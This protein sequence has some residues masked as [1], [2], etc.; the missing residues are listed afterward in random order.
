MFFF[1]HAAHLE[2]W[3]TVTAYEAVTTLL[4]SE[5]IK[6]CESLL[7]VGGGDG[8]YCYIIVNLR[9]IFYCRETLK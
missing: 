2:K 1:E 6:G 8:T 5:A 9:L 4:K 7:D 3:M